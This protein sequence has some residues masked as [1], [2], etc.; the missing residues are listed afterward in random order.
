VDLVRLWKL[1]KIPLVFSRSLYMSAYTGPTDIRVEEGRIHIDG[2]PNAE[3]LAAMPGPIGK[4]IADLRLH[5]SDLIFCENA[6]TELAKI[7]NASGV[8]AR[9]LWIAALVKFFSCFGSNKASAPLSPRRKSTRISK[10]RWMSMRI[11]RL[12]ETSM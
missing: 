10:E 5:Q 8:L 1:R 4:R 3:R 12:S 6:V 11:S 2:Y 7:E 9:A